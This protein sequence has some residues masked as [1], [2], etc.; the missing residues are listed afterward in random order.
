MQSTIGFTEQDFIR[1]I[2]NSSNQEI[3]SFFESSTHLSSSLLSAVWFDYSFRY[4]G[5]FLH[6]CCYTVARN[7]IVL[8]LL[9]ICDQKGIHIETMLKQ[10]DRPYRRLAIH[11]AAWRGLLD[12][13]ERMSQKMTDHDLQ[14][15]E[16]HF[17]WTI[18]HWAAFRNQK[19]IINLLLSRKGH[20]HW[21]HIRDKKGKT[22]SG[23]AEQYGFHDLVAIIL[24]ASDSHQNIQQHQ[25]QQR[26]IILNETSNI[27]EQLQ[28]IEIRT[29]YPN[30]SRTLKDLRDHGQTSSSVTAFESDLA[31]QVHRRDTESVQISQDRDRDRDVDRD[32][33]GE[34]ESASATPDSEEMNLEIISQLRSEI[35]D[36]KER[37]QF[38][39]KENTKQKEELKAMQEREKERRAEIERLLKRIRELEKV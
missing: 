17:G 24:E 3:L 25:Q 18:L 35:A 38:L 32:G 29:Q 13:V 28:P 15:K 1:L 9:Q 31:E 21:N 36:T 37:M 27:P 34:P 39:E 23:L 19:D 30:R 8:P 33:E 20:I 12:V 4:K 7:E 11:Y 14:K 2:K 26:E 10:E 22:A 5:S 16:D 6:Y